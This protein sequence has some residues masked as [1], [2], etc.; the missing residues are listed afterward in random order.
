MPICRSMGFL[1][2]LTTILVLGSVVL[3]AWGAGQNLEYFVAPNGNDSW[4]G[5][6]AVPNA[7]RTDG[8]FATLEHARDAVRAARQEA[9][10]K[11]VGAA[12]VQLRGGTYRVTRTFTLESRDGGTTAAPT[13]YRAYR[14][15]EVRLVGGQEVAGWQPVRDE[16]ILKRLDPTAQNHVV[17]SD[18]HAQGVKDYG[19]LTPRGFGRPTTPA[20]LELFFQDRPM[21]LARWPNGNAWATIQGA[22][23][24]AEGSV[25]TYEGDR[26]ARWAQAEDAWV[27]G[28][29]S[30][31]W[32]D[33]YEKVVSIDPVTHSIFTH[34]AQGFY[35]Y[36]PGRRFYALNLLEELDTPGEYYLDRK[37]GLLYFWPPAL[38]EKGRTVVSVLEAPLITVRNAAHILLRGLTLEAGRGSGLEMIDCQDCLVAGCMLR[39]LG[40]DGINITGGARCGVQA[41]DLY[42]TG[43]SGVHIGGGDRKTLTPS[44]HYVVNCEIHHQSRWDRTYRPAIGIDGVGNRASHNLI[45]DGP[46]NAIL[47]S[48]NDHIVEY[49]DISRVCTQTG[50]AG[51]VYMGRDLV[52][53]GTVV[54]YNHF[55]DIGPTIQATQE[56]RYTEVMAVYLDDCYCG[57]TISG[58]LFERAGRSIMVGGGR[59]NTIENNIFV[60]CS[61]AIHVDQ[62]GKSWAAKY[63][64]PNSEWRIL[65]HAQEVPYDQPPY[66]TRYPHIVNVLS[67]DPAAAK[68]NRILRNIR[69][70]SGKWIDWLDGLSEK[71]VETR[72]N[73]TEGDPGFVAPA[74][75]DYRLRPDAPALK[76]GFQPLPLSKIGL[77]RDAYRGKLPVN[78]KSR[79]GK[80]E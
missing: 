80:A 37:T 76:T 4:S 35:G 52:Q 41:C 1:A 6:L 45:H 54:R 63:F 60:D 66:S 56:G 34:P 2:A 16:A 75:H 49:N 7:G 15:E 28:Y 26:P 36:A 21:T 48:G 62:R 77:E 43:D 73:W 12:T 78:R 17:Q 68:Y 65:E 25:F 55:H 51:A 5:R 19:S 64:L 46:H 50:D 3:P 57:V 40:T 61:P 9:G 27:H 10:T 32:A 71:T 47:M 22:P 44:G 8:P 23:K 59:D 39:N 24:G 14:N 69:A 33:T 42:E 30:F 79:S 58:N 38:L 31:D 74:N 18:L 70:G 53:R 20:A 11:G 29:W 72:D 13:V 67:D